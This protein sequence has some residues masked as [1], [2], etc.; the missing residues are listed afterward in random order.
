MSI[1]SKIVIVDDEKLITDSLAM[2]LAVEGFDNACFFNSPNEALEYLNNN[3]PDIVISDFLMPE[4]NGIDFLREVKKLY[5]DVSTILLTGYS[6][7]ENAIKAINEVA[8][9]KYIVKP[10]DNDDLI[11]NIKN[12]IERSNLMRNLKDKIS[13]LEQAQ[14]ELKKYSTSLE[15]IVKIRSKELLETNNQLSALISCCA[16]GIM[17]TDENGKILT[18]NP[19]CENMFSVGKEIIKDK[20]I[21]DVLL[22]EDNENI[23]DYL[24]PEQEVIVRNLYFQNPLTNKNVPFEMSLAP[25]I[26]ENGGRNFVAVL[27][28]VSVQKEMERLRNDFIATLT[29][30][31]RTPLLAAIQ[32]LGFF[33]NNSLGEITEEQ[34]KFLDTMKRSNEDMLGLV[35]ALLEVYKYE[36]GQISLCKTDFIINDLITDCVEQVISLAKSKNILLET[37]IDNTSGV[38]INAD[39]NEIRRVIVNLLGNAI[40]HTPKDGSVQIS[41]KTEANSIF[42][43]V[44]DTGEGI[45]KTDIAKIFNRFSQGTSN[46]RSVGT[47]LGLFL[48]R[49]IVEAHNGKIWLESVLGKGSTF[50]FCLKECIKE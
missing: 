29:H 19:A 42:V 22:S 9:Y 2:L 46:K 37:A 40:N 48:S 18:L 10:W 47:G 26:L 7:K 13:Q 32:T 31:L 41:A 43:S 35:N 21:S 39:K 38:K 24:N 5:P 3:A 16:D 23:K 11:L 50:S 6:D 14:A 12:G 25:I 15:E 36:A 1:N 49:Q 8:L 4:M 20:N 33:L 17:T 34:R 30:D 28:D 27:R 45:H 44:K